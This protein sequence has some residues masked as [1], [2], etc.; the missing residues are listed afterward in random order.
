MSNDCDFLVI[1]AGIAGASAA[2]FLAEKGRV[3]VLEREDAPGY[4]TTGRSAALFIASTGPPT[5]CALARAAQSFLETP[6]A[7][8]AG[9]PLMTPRGALTIARPG[10]EGALA[11]LFTDI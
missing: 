6:P 11:A 8:F 7:G 5:V 1:G 10:E 4:H 2:Y 3:T 9:H